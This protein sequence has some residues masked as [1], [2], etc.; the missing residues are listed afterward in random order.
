MSVY[1]ILQL[2]VFDEEGLAAYRRVAGSTLQGVNVKALAVGSDAETIE[3]DWHGDR[4][5][6]L[7]FETAESFRSWYNSPGYQEVVKLRLD[8]TD[9]RSALVKGLE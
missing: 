1:F 8:A 7:E 3:G 6:L 9:S 4:V 2:K 5:T